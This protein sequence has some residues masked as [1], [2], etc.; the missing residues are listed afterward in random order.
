[1][2]GVE[3]AAFQFADIDVATFAFVG[4]IAFLAS[5]LGGVSGYGV[6]LILPIF[7]APVVGVAGVVPAMAVSMAITNLGRVL[8]FRRELDWRRAGWALLGAVPF[9]VL[10]A[11]VYTLLP[12]A[13]IAL[14][15]GLCLVGSVPL[16]RALD[17]AGW[18]IGPAGIVVG[19]ATYGLFVGSMSGLGAIVLATLM[20]AGLEGAA[21][22]GTD[23]VVSLAT[24]IVK[25][26]VFGTRAS[27]DLELATAGLLMGLCTIPGAFAGRWL[28]QRFPMRVHTGLMDALVLLGGV[29]FL[30]RW[31]TGAL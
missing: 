19:G 7:L 10:S 31:W 18:R 26:L 28:L 3:P 6:G 14:V 12:V 8:A 24:N 5:V 11:Y 16:R 30:W 4:A 27:L 17:R 21:L 22:I 9:C 23:A 2:T 20:A 1:M 25:V 15:L 29:S 13:G